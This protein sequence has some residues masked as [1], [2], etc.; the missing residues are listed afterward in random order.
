MPLSGGFK[1]RLALA[2][3]YVKLKGVGIATTEWKRTRLMPQRH[4]RDGCE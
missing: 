4:R 1:H 2:D 3:P